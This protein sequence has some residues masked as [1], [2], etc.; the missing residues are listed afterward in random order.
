MKRIIEALSTVL[1]VCAGVRVA[2]WLVVP[3]TPVIAVFLFLAL[4][5]FVIL[6]GPRSGIKPFK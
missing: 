5:V 6:F 3:L 4:V 1:L 2:A